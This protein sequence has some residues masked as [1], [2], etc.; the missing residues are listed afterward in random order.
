[1][2]PS[3][4]SRKDFSIAIKRRPLRRSPSFACDVQTCPKR[5]GEFLKGCG[6][7]SFWGSGRQYR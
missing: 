3:Y 2:L 4:S 5:L 1:M 6:T 7:N